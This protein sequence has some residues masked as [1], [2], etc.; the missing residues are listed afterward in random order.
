MMSVPPHMSP[1]LLPAYPFGTAAGLQAH[2]KAK[3]PTREKA[4][5]VM[6]TDMCVPSIGARC[7]FVQ[8]VE[9]PPH[10]KEPQLVNILPP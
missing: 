9:T 1:P 10:P 6:R 3:A 4:E 5:V 8:E 7:S 2:P